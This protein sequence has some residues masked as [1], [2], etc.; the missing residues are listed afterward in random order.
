MCNALFSR[1]YS[2][3]VMSLCLLSFFLLLSFSPL[4]LF[5][6]FYFAAV[7]AG[8]CD[9]WKRDHP[10]DN[11]SRALLTPRIDDECRTVW[12]S[13]VRKIASLSSRPTLSTTRTIS[14]PQFT[15]EIFAFRGGKLLTHIHT[16]TLT[17]KKHFQQNYLVQVTKYL[18][19]WNKIFSR[20]C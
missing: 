3:F 4:S 16:H 18:A 12:G 9:S 6:Y 8:S 1:W 15:R 17:R 14:P 11:Y 13:A 19:L 20:F 2:L 7:T 10:R 5:L